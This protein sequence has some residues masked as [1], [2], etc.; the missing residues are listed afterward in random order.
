MELHE[1]V[2]KY[3]WTELWVLAYYRTI[4]LVPD[5]SQWD[6]SDEIKTLKVLSLPPKKK[7]GRTKVLRFPSTGERRPKDQRT[8]KKK[9]LKQSLQWLLF[10]IHSV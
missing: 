7:K 4:Y 3:Y 6:I 2:S 8:Q 1:L 5:R 10:G 9:R